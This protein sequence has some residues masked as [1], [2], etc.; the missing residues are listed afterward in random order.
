MI[1][2]DIQF[3]GEFTMTDIN[4]KVILDKM[5]EKV[6][7]IFKK[8]DCISI[9]DKAL[10]EK[11]ETI[12]SIVTD[13]M[14]RGRGGA[15]F[16][17]GIKWKGAASATGNTK[18]IICNADEGEPGTFKDRMILDEEADKVITGMAICAHAIGASEGYIYLRGEYNFLKDKLQEACDKWNAQFAYKKLNFCVAVRSGSGAYV[19]GE[20]TAL[21]ESM[22]GNRG[23]PR[24]KP[25]FPVAA[26]YMDEPTVINNVETLAYVTTIIDK[27]SKY[28]KTIGTKDSQGGK[29]FSVSGD[30][31]VKG[32][33]ELPMGMKMQ[34]FVDLFGDGDTKAVQVGGS[35]GTCVPRKNFSSTVIG[36]EGVPTGGSMILFNSRR[37]MFHVLKNFLEFFEE[38]SCG[39]CT[40]CRVGCQQL[41]KGIEAIRSGERPLEYINELRKLAVTMSVS[42]KCGLGQSLAS[43]FNSITEHFREEICY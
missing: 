14:L 8:A 16:P 24:N 9:L 39:Q 30:C 15:G 37:S 4:K 25:P 22:E 2:P 33:Y 27:G 32:V 1:C 23:E 40:P 42:S 34:E 29:V 26:G 36:F 35:S 20:E 11:P 38:E 3:E 17:T 7:L 13:S 18:Y 10:S 31:A 43:P 19:C 12:I 28:F 5:Q 41:L 6:N 21:I